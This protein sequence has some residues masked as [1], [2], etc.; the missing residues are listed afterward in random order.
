MI[1]TLLIISILI[2]SV[3]IGLTIKNYFSVR[4]QIYLDFKD[5]IQ[6][7]KTE[8][9]FLKTDKISLLKKQNCSSKVAQENLNDYIEAGQAETKFLNQN[10]NFKLNEFLN[11][12]GKN[13][14][15]GE[16]MGLQ[17]YENI[18]IKD[19]N[20]SEEKLN[21]YGTFSVKLAIIIGTLIAI[22]LI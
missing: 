22:I 3:V 20:L 9:T 18:I 14:I 13:N 4:H 12:I 15:D 16:I 2:V 6:S 21:K 10:E 19:C 1:K 8:I 17:Y 5:I 7:I 11:S